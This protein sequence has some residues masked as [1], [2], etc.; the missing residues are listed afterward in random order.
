MKERL[1][2]VVTD[3]SINNLSIKIVP[4]YSVQLCLHQRSRYS[5]SSPLHLTNRLWQAQWGKNKN[6]NSYFKMPKLHFPIESLWPTLGFLFKKGRAC[7]NLH[8]SRGVMRTCTF[9]CSQWFSESCHAG[10]SPQVFFL[11]SNISQLPAK[12]RP[13]YLV[14]APPP[15]V[16][17]LHGKEASSRQ[18]AFITV[19]VKVQVHNVS[20]LD[21]GCNT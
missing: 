3:N 12:M 11:S 5:L 8:R 10:T 14:F 9:S 20:A 16:F 17:F 4:P 18:L 6:K 15:S 13:A 7:E 2:K 21:P 1:P 19:S